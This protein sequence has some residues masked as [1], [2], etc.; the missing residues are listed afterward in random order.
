MLEFVTLQEEHAFVIWAVVDKIAQSSIAL[1]MVLAPTKESVMIPVESANVILDLKD[2][3]V[4]INHV[5]VVVP[6]VMAMVNVI[7]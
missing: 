2:N 4:K 1:V 3:L 7:S 6:H 5:L